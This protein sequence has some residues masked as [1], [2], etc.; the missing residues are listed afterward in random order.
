MSQLV[1]MMKQYFKEVNESKGALFFAVCR[2]KVL[3]P[4][5]NIIL[6]KNF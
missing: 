5:L 6:L 3:F 2:G 4:L 1:G